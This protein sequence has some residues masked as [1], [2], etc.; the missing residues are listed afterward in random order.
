MLNPCLRGF[1]RRWLFK[2]NPAFREK[3]RAQ[4]QLLN[5]CGTAVEPYGRLNTLNTPPSRV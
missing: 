3:R 2:K 4:I 1:N 5:Y